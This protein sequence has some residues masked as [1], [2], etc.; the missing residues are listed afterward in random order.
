M[1]TAFQSVCWREAHF[2][3]CE[4]TTCFRQEDIEMVKALSHIRRGELNTDTRAF[5]RRCARQLRDDDGITPTILYA[6]NR[7]VDAANL[8]NL[9]ALPGA[10]YTYEAQDTVEVNAGVQERENEREKEGEKQHAR[11]SAE[12]ALKSD[13]FFSHQ[14]LV[15]QTVALKLNAQV[16]LLKNRAQVMHEAVSY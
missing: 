14:C 16:M 5:L 12:R 9:Q 13:A 10:L 1:S 2:V 11:A 6:T 4:L 7:N 8:G 3:T 15:P